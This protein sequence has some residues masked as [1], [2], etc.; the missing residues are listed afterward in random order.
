MANYDNI[1]DLILV[2]YVNVGNLDEQDVAEHIEMIRIRIANDKPEDTAPWFYIPVRGEDT[3]V[4]CLN[5]K[6]I[7]NETLVANAMFQLT[8]INQIFRDKVDNVFEVDKPE[9]FKINKKIV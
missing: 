3:R 7:A 2:F 4:E 5:P 8:E 1:K 6:F 9:T